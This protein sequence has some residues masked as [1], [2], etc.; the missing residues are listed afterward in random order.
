MQKHAQIYTNY[1]AIGQDDR[2][3]C[4]VCQSKQ[5]VDIHHIYGR[6]KGMNIIENLIGLCRECHNDAHINK[7]SK[8][9]LTE[10][11]LKNL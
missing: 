3:L 10:I 2:P 1:F 11:H 5:I 8:D 6:G 7:I 4:E 9:Q